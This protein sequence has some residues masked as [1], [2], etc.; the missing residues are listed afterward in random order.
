M[1]VAA[2]IAVRVDDM[3]MSGQSPFVG[4]QTTKNL[5]RSYKSQWPE[6]HL[7]KSEY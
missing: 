2:A 7:G 1:R 6:W 3:G 4:S 5:L